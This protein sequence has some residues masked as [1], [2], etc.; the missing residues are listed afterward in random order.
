M[1]CA[2]STAK[3]ETGHKASASQ[4]PGAL[5]RSGE[6]YSKS[7]SPEAS[8]SRTAL[9]SPGDNELLSAAARSPL[10]QAAST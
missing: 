8:A 10:A 9:C 5:R 3:K 2:P 7:S 1:Q 6:M 4:K